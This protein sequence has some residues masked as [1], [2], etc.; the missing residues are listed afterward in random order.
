MTH[1]KNAVLERITAADLE[2][3][4]FEWHEKMS[5][6]S[7]DIQVSAIRYKGT[8]Y[9]CTFDLYQRKAFWITYSPG[10]YRFLEDHHIGSEWNEVLPYV[11][12]WLAYLKREIEEPDLW[13]RIQN[14]QLPDG[15]IPS[16]D[17]SNEQFTAVE[18]EQLERSIN[19]VRG[20]LAEHYGDNEEIN[21]KLNYLI[22]SSKRMGRKDWVNICMGALLSLAASQAFQLEHVQ[23]VWNMIKSALSGIVLF[24]PPSAVQ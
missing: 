13:A 10:R 24:L 15:S 9:H 20:F 23:T 11:T 7:S 22:E 12:R 8:E 1:Q 21:G 3:F 19:E 5:L 14:Y 16:D 4:N 2:P 18:V 6:D 17:T